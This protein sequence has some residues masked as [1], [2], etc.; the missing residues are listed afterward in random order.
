MTRRKRT[1]AGR[2][3][4]T[5]DFGDMMDDIVHGAAK[6]GIT[7]SQMTRDAFRAYARRDDGGVSAYHLSVLLLDLDILREK[8][9]QFRNN[10]TNKQAADEFQEALD[11]VIVSADVLWRWLPK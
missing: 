1:S 6:L 9:I 7:V 11:W 4:L 8:Y 2:R 5:V 10:P 3:R